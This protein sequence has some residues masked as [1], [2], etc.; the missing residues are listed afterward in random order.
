MAKL[1]TKQIIAGIKNGLKKE[2]PKPAP[3]K[4]APGYSVRDM[5]QEAMD[6]GS[7]GAS[8]YFK[9]NQQ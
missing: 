8:E 7:Y 2:A 3:K 1:T 6:S 9:E 4:E 5:R